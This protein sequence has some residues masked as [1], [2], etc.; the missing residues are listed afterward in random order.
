VI[1]KNA[2]ML[3]QNHYI[4]GVR[5]KYGHYFYDNIKEKCVENTVGIKM[6]E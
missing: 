6:M 1:A 4:S 2:L 3:Q 5:K